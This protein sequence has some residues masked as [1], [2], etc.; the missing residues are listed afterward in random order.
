MTS[1]RA[2]FV[3]LALGASADAQDK[4]AARIAYAQGS[5]FYDLNQYAEA[6]DAF[7]RAY[8]NYE[9][10]AILYNIAQCHRALGHKKEA[11]D[12]Y[13]SYIR[14]SPAAR[15]RQDVEK[16]IAELNGALDNER[17]VS[18]APPLGTLTSDGKPSAPPPPRV[19][20]EAPPA[21][22]L[23]AKKTEITPP[24]KRPWIWGVVAGSV[25]LV[26][27]AVGVGVGIGVRPQAPMPTD[28]T[29]RF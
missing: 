17:A 14:K 3:L 27:V 21:P 28:G 7:K 18:A 26:G 1:L 22:V 13:R 23:V 8:W 4:A 10:P 12:F 29:W 6:L 15:N 20:P 25:V 11:V 2:V 16:I 9:E 24:K 19:V 5:K